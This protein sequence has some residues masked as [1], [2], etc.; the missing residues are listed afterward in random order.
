MSEDIFNDQDEPNLVLPETENPLL[1]DIS[2]YE[3]RDLLD[4]NELESYEDI[5]QEYYDPSVPTAEILPPKGGNHALTMEDRQFE[6]MFG[7]EEPQQ[8]AFPEIPPEED[9]EA[10]QV[11]EQQKKGRPKHKKG[12]GLF[13]IPNILVTLVWAALT[14]LI[15]VTLGRMIWICAAD[16]L[17][18]GKEDRPVTITI[19]E[20]DDIDAITDKLYNAHLIRYPGLFRLYASFAVDDGEI[21]PG[22][23]DLNAKYDY[24]ALVR[25]MTPSSSREVVTVLIP[26][27]FSC[28]Q[29]FTTL[30][31]NKVCTVD[32]IS[33]YAANGELDDFWFMEF[34]ERGDK[35]CLE[36]FLFPDTYEFYKNDSPR[37]VLEKMLYNFDNRFTEEMFWQIDQLN[38]KMSDTMRYNGRNDDYIKAHLLS[39]KDL[40]TVASMVEKETS[41]AEEGHTIAS[42]IYNRLYDWGSTPAYLNID[43]T[44]IYALDGKTNLVAEDLR[45]DS[46]Y[47]TYINVGLTPGPI[48]NPGLAS[49]KA[50]LEPEN[51]DYYYYILDPETGVHKFSRTEE[52]HEA[53]RESLRG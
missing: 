21:K 13:G 41:S 47:N 12:E 6:E 38:G 30:E 31:E 37:N 2:A 16:V 50:A 19:Y 35:Y 28:R 27:G 43:A 34:I 4:S 40:I 46:P 5:S 14:L 24:H 45:V 42:V 33:E 8:D 36:G 9:I 52:E 39:P 18:F 51:T 15:G 10:T 1:P 20:N 26:E 32:A 44:V 49:I 23:W 25:M 22:I 7:A 11:E 48:C 3:P 53:F 17:A 29:I